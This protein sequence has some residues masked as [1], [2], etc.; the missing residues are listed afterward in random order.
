MN[1]VEDSCIK[2]EESIPPIPRR[3]YY[4]NEKKIKHFRDGFIIG[5]LIASMVRRLHTFLILYCGCIGI[6][7]LSMLYNVR[8]IQI[9]D[10]CLQM[11][12]Q[13]QKQAD[14][15]LLLQKWYATTYALSNIEYHAMK[16]DM[17]RPNQIQF[18]S[19]TQ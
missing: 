3:Y 19:L 8:C 13:K 9:H 7:I 1:L 5:T 4:P 16:L 2:K 10:D 17:I 18:I 11:T 14:Q 6:V 15:L 12:L